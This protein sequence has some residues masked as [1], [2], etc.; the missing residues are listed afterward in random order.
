[1]HVWG[2]GSQRELSTINPILVEIAE[3]VLQIRDI[4]VIQ[5]H[6]DEGTQNRYYSQ[7]VSKV[8]WPYSKHNTYPSKA[9]DVQ[10]SPYV[11]ETLREDLTYIAGLFVGVGAQ[12]GHKLRWGG[13]WDR[14]G[15]TADNGFD[16]LFHIE[17]DDESIPES[18]T[19]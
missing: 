19:S 14:D 12:M 2:R 1:M 5:G 18:E 9:L 17:L 10:P 15:E 16:D 7:G 4:T 11:E 13:D 8:K 3:K 6:R